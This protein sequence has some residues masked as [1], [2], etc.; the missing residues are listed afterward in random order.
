MSALTLADFESLV[1]RCKQHDE[2]LRRSGA[3]C[4]GGCVRCPGQQEKH[5]R[6]IRSRMRRAQGFVSYA[7]VSFH[8][9]IAM[10][11]RL[12]TFV[13]VA[14]AAAAPASAQLQPPVFL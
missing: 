7:L 9:G 4:S 2:E 5:D 8:R 11:Y 3:S 14:L 6:A 10:R 13:W 1:G 12:A